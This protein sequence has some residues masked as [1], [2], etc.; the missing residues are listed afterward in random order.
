[1]TD[2]FYK[3][4]TAEDKLRYN[5]LNKENV[6][7]LMERYNRVNRLVIADMIRRSAYHYPDKAAVVFGDKTLTYAQLEEA[8][9]RTANALADLGVKKYDRVAILA[10][11][12][13]HHVLT[14]LGCCKIGAVY[15][16]INY[17]L[18]GKDVTYCIDHSE[19]KVFI[20]EDAL[21]PLVEDVL[22]DMKTVDTFIWS[23]D[24]AGQ[25]PPS[26][27]FKDFESWYSAYPAT[28][29]D[30]I[31]R[32]EDPCQMT[33]TSGT[34]SLPKGVIISNQALI[35]QYMGA[36]IDGRYDTNDINV[37]ALPIY[38]C[39]ARDVFM[40]PV[41][42]VGGTN[43]LMA[44]DLGE[45]LA[46]IDKYRAT[47]FFAPPTVWIGLLR[48]PDFD[49]YDLSCLTK[50]YYGASIMPVEV[51]K[52]I[53]ERFPDAGVY[54]YYGQTELAPY[55]TVL[56]AEDALGKLG[57]AG[58]A[59]LNMESRLEDEFGETITELGAPGEICGKGPHAM[60]MY[61][62]E[63]EKTE[64]AMKGG[65]FHSGDI[66]VLDEDR[67]IS[68]VD[69]K[70]DMIKTG[71]ENV[72]TREV[73]EVV[74]LDKRVEEVAVIGVEHAKWVEAV[75]AVVV[76]RAGE[77]IAEDEIMDLCKEHLAPFK[78]PKRVIIV[79]ALP[80]TP[81]GK[82]LKRDMRQQYKDIFKGA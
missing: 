54:N 32:I 79:D 17:L 2:N 20:V 12:T 75:T 15:L 37:N 73:E 22:D 16:A 6:D 69:R 76:P 82:I 40:N 33:Y 31:L 30:V 80:K 25:G 67:Y 78:T 50:C 49:K 59:G 23:D 8:A 10:H 28:E 46:T 36:I 18:K 74:Y 55:H 77:T 63:P 45:V 34:E 5:T 57:S 3:P 19:S 42:W 24:F 38:H 58:M 60:I 51:L 44:P 26:D 14:W 35:A 11:N 65:W 39:A 1:M 68:V 62:K 71:G 41:F 21:Y 9:N 27:R 81:T 53:L 4:M 43:V 47:M 64:D 66:G 72:S 48:H 61:F 7:F 70:K 52:E 56:K 29:P 13:I